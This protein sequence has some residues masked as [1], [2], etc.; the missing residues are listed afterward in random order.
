MTHAIG[1]MELPSIKV[2]GRLER[3]GFKGRIITIILAALNWK[4]IVP[5]VTQGKGIRL[6]P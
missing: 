5:V 3:L 6:E 4:C 2:K 1:K